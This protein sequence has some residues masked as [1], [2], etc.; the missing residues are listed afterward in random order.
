M[1]K[2][3]NAAAPSGL[4]QFIH[5]VLEPWGLAGPVVPQGTNEP[6]I[7]YGSRRAMALPGQVNNAV[8]AAA[9]GAIGSALST[10][11]QTPRDRAAAAASAPAAAA[12]PAVA[13][14]VAPA[15]TRDMRDAALQQAAAAGLADPPNSYDKSVANYASGNGGQVSL[16]ALGALAH[17]ASETSAYHMQVRNQASN[18]AIA[19]GTALAEK[20]HEQKLAAIDAV[21]GPDA[22][23]ARAKA[24]ED[25]AAA[26]NIGGAKTNP[27][28]DAMARMLSN[29]NPAPGQ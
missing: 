14:A 18:D 7:A 27:M 1:A 23:T 10:L 24:D 26:Y 28:A 8:G 19:K 2:N 20:I 11:I 21:P 12:H 16:R 5:N 13:A 3:P 22:A 15:V 29:S 17:I 9:N 25:L 4:G 6:D